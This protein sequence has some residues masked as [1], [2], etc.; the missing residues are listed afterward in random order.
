MLKVIEYRDGQ[1]IH[2]T[3]SDVAGFYKSLR[4]A[5]RCLDK[6][7]EV[8][9]AYN[10]QKAEVNR[11]ISLV[12]SCVRHQMTNCQFCYDDITKSRAASDNL[13]RLRKSLQG[14]EFRLLQYMQDC[15]EF[16]NEDV[17]PD[18]I[19]K[20]SDWKEFAGRAGACG[21]KIFNALQERLA[22][23][24][25]VRERD[26]LSAVASEE[27]EK[28][29]QNPSNP[30]PMT[31]FSSFVERLTYEGFTI[32]KRTKRQTEPVKVGE[33]RH[34][35]NGKLLSIIEFH[36]PGLEVTEEEYHISPEDDGYLDTVWRLKERKREFSDEY[37]RRIFRKTGT[38]RFVGMRLAPPTITRYRQQ[39]EQRKEIIAIANAPRSK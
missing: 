12:F 37:R 14:L 32:S 39:G 33:I 21:G 2:R 34:F 9:E 6:R 38:G 10:E 4:Q 19:L 5:Y 8:E 24:K 27:K 18:W 7:N 30:H 26:G 3:V 15:W 28:I 25:M 31:K 1:F 29:F 11:K 23:W 36:A 16:A 20:E 22:Y 13:A 35:R 17:K